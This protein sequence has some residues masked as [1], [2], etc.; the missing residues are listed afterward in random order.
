MYLYKR[1]NCPIKV[2]TKFFS[3]SQAFWMI[4][5]KKNHDVIVVKIRM[6]CVFK[7]IPTYMTCL[8]FCSSFIDVI[9]HFLGNNVLNFFFSVSS[10][11]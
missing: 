7:I 2:D 5:A 3:G 11:Y 6:K 1:N 9:V 4:S 8:N 10:Y